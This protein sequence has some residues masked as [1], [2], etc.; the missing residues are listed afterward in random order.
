MHEQMC[1]KWKANC[2]KAK[3]RRVS[4]KYRSYHTAEATDQVVPD[5]IGT[6]DK[7]QSKPYTHPHLTV[8]RKKLHQPNRE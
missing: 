6:N 8:K 2:E 3:G 1:E 5:T 4:T 7:Y